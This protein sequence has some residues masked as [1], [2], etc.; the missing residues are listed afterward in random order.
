MQ[1]EALYVFAVLKSVLSSQRNDPFIKALLLKHG[2]TMDSVAL[3]FFK[4]G[5]VEKSSLQNI[6]EF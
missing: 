4:T 2:I 3:D 6:S 5:S 1:V